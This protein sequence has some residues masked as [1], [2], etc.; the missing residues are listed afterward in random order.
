MTLMT[1]AAAGA[2]VKTAAVRAVRRSFCGSMPI[3]APRRQALIRKQTDC[4]STTATA[5]PA[6]TKRTGLLTLKSMCRPPFTDL[7]L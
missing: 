4:A 2:I 3:A 1:M 6:T 7:P 5:I